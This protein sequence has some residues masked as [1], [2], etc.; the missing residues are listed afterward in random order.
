MEPLSIAGAFAT[1]LGLICNFKSEGKAISDNE[2]KTFLEWLQSK[3][4]DQIIKHIE[5]NIC[6]AD[7]IRHF[8]HEDNKIILRKLEALDDMAAKIASSIEGLAEISQAIRPTL[9]LSRQSINIL[10]QLNNSGG[11]RF[12]ELQVRGNTIFQV[13]DG[14]GGA[15]IDYDEP[16]FIEDDL[17]MMVE[18]GVLRLERN[19]QGRRFFY[20]T[21]EAAQLLTTCIL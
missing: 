8:L 12:T 11:S 3:R 6:L 18:L 1:I 19:A 15:N 16:R 21:R 9:G 5:A 7:S 14:A 4:H 17:L 20:F 13:V 10:R 2:Y